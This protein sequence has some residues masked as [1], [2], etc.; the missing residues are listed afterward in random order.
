[1]LA[2]TLI[3][4][5]KGGKLYLKKIVS[6]LSLASR[7][8]NKMLGLCQ[9]YSLGATLAMKAHTTIIAKKKNSPP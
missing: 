5:R 7:K 1:M 6:D 8:E 9:L 2:V 4:S 3:Y